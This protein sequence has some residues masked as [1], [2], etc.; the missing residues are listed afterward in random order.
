M[1]IE[2]LLYIVEEKGPLKW[3]SLENDPLTFVAC[4]MKT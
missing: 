3:W 1:G 4:V 2:M